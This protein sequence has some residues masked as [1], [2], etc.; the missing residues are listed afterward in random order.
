MKGY[1]DLIIGP[2]FS[3][4]TSSLINHYNRYRVYNQKVCIINYEDDT[5]YTTHGISTHDKVIVNCIMSKTLK[6]VVEKH[7]DNYDVFLINEGQF[8]KDLFDSVFH[9]VEV[10]H[11]RVHI[12]AL[13]GSF[14]REPMGDILKLIPLCDNVEKKHAVCV[15]CDDGTNAIFSKRLSKDTNEILISS[16][17]YIAVCRNC[18]HK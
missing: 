17:D 12:A 8:F 6:E 2:M 4:K 16:T 1:L 15:Q 18:Y 3:G 7:I 10:K 14:K 11:K 5:R 13:D 9:L